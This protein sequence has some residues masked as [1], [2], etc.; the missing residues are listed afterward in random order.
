[1][2]RSFGGDD[3]AAVRAPV[4]LV[5]DGLDST[6]TPKNTPIPIASPP[7][8][9]GRPNLLTRRTIPTWDFMPAATTPS[10]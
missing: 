8:T 10:P 5:G 3:F 2:V 4:F 7:T 1:M 6:P 9:N